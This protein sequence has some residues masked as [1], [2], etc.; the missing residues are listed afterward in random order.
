MKKLT[1]ILL[2]VLLLLALAGCGK[3]E[4]PAPTAE[5]T[6]EPSE[7]PAATETLAPTQA[8]AEEAPDVTATVEAIR[9]M[10]GQ[11]V[12]DLYDFIGEPTGGTDYGPSCLVTGGQDGQLFYEGFCVYTIVQ[13][14][15]AE[16]IYDVELN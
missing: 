9:E 3:T 6:A 1:A 7:A 8:P 14:D 10:I 16:S 12:Q 13:P 4:T 15:G 2:C 11:P 5:P